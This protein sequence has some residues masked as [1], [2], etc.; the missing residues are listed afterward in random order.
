MYDQRNA[1][2]NARFGVP[3]AWPGIGCVDAGV[4]WLT[5]L[6]EPAPEIRGR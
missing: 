1:A 3:A 5:N 4:R 2:L 6:I